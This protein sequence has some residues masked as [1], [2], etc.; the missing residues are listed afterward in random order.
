MQVL[1]DDPLGRDARKS[2]PAVERL[3]LHNQQERAHIKASL[4]H[5]NDHDSSTL[6]INPDLALGVDVDLELF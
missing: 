6:L 4:L 3:H 2:Y 5:V 1:W